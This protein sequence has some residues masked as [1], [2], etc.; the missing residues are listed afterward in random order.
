MSISLAI[1]SA[2]SRQFASHHEVAKVAADLK[3][4]AKAQAGSVYV[5]DRCQRPCLMSN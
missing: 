3:K 1:V 5:K 2:D 4:H